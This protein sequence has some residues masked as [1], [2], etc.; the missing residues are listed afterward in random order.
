MKICYIYQYTWFD[1]IVFRIFAFT[2]M[3]KI[4]IDV[5]FFHDPYQLLILRLYSLHEGLPW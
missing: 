5:L 4:E 1:N 2:I 3:T